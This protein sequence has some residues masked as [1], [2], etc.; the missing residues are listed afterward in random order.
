[1]PGK[2][3]DFLPFLHSWSGTP[4][5]ARLPPATSQPHLRSSSGVAGVASLSRRPVFV[6]SGYVTT[7]PMARSKPFIPAIWDRKTRF[8]S[9]PSR[10]LAG[11]ASRPSS[12]PNGDLDADYL[13]Q[14]VVANYFPDAASSGGSFALNTT[15]HGTPLGVE[16]SAGLDE[17][18]TRRNRLL[19]GHGL[20]C[21]VIPSILRG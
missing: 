15:D 10:A 18:A 8:T 2:R 9:A 1:M 4:D 21:T 16:L 7:G 5:G 11:S 20:S 13:G 14:A 12:I 3:R 19:R 6:P 17:A